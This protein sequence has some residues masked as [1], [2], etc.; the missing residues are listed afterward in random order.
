MFDQQRHTNE[1][2]IITTRGGGTH[3]K[4]EPKFEMIDEDE[5]RGGGG[6]GGG[7][8]DE[9]NDDD[10]EYEDDEYS[11]TA[12]GHS[13]PSLMMPSTTPEP[14]ATKSASLSSTL[15]S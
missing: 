10:G 4:Q 6:G 7:G 12:S 15:V 2:K 13:T 8:D 9:F 3:V 1:L 14:T 11:Y 5:Q